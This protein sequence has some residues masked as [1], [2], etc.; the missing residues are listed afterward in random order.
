[1]K[2][3]GILKALGKNGHFDKIQNWEKY[4]TRLVKSFKIVKSWKMPNSF[5]K[6]QNLLN[7]LRN[8]L[9]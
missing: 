4:F 6:I 2:N 7:E 1:M 8:A 9:K 5:K 3:Q